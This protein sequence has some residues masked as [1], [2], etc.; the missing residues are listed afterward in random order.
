[1]RSR[2][3]TTDPAAAADVIRP[4]ERFLVATHEAPDGDALGSMLATK[5]A[6]DQLGKD[7]VMYLAGDVP[8][9]REYHFMALDELRRG[10]P[11][12]DAGERVLLALDCAKEARLGGDE[13]LL[14][15]APLVVNIDHHHDNTARGHVNLI[16]PDAAATRETM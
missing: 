3:S 9:P 11:P 13:R 12:A 7:A 15:I 2:R 6:L 5:L 8:L 16:V 4:H 10:E 1:M 14:E